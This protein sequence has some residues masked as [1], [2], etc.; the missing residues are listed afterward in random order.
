MSQAFILYS[1]EGCHLCEQALELCYQ[2]LAPASIKVVDIVDDDRLVELYGVYIPVL[3][4][5]A[6]GQKLFWPFTAEQV[7]ELV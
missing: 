3:E 7:G 1:S 2:L 5:L 4:R 6:D